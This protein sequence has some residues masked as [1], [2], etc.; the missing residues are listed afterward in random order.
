MLSGYL[1]IV[2]LIAAVLAVLVLIWRRK[3]F[4]PL[5]LLVPTFGMWVNLTQETRFWI[6][7]TSILL[8][9]LAIVL[10]DLLHTRPA[11]FKLATLGGIALWALTMWLPFIT[12]TDPLRLPLPQWDVDQYI[13]SDAT[14]FGMTALGDYLVEQEA[15]TVI[16]ILANC[17][18]LKYTY[19]HDLNVL[20]PQISPDGKQ[21]PALVAL[22]DANQQAGS[23]AVIEAIDYLPDS[24]PGELV[25]TIERPT[26]GP[27]F[28]IYHLGG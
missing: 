21:T 12:T 15:Q 1:G 25:A 17:L 14:G 16:G 2:V 26:S 5:M 18:A 3:L 23:Y 28:A 7:A 19:L 6:P 27:G 9:S 22:M 8:L 13:E 4:L 10:A 24:A 20:C 11:I